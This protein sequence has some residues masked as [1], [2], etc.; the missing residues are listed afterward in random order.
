MSD[1]D[2]I[3]R[4]HAEVIRSFL[5]DAEPPVFQSLNATARDRSRRAVVAVMAGAALVVAAL[6]PMLLLGDSRAHLTTTNPP[7]PSVG[8]FEES[9]PVSPFDVESFLQSKLAGAFEDEAEQRIGVVVLAPSG[10]ESDVEGLL[11]GLPEFEGYTQLG[12]DLVGTA[13][14]RFAETHD[15]EPF[16]GEWVAFGLIP[17]FAD[18]PTTEWVSTLST[19]PDV[20]VALVD[21][22]TPTVRIP[23]GWSEVGDLPFHIDGGAIVGGF[24]SRI[25]VLQSDS[26]T[27]IDPDGSYRTGD[28][29]PISVPTDCCGSARVMPADEV[30]VVGSWIL[31]P[32]TLTWREADP[33][34]I[35]GSVLGSAFLDGELFVVTAAA[36]TGEAISKLAS[37]NTATGSW[38]ELES[39]PSPISVGGVTTDGKRLIVAGTRQDGNNLIIG[40][41]NPVVYQYT[42]GERW[43]ELPS[44]P[45]DG[46]ASTV[47]WVEGVGL[48]VWNYELQSALLDGSGTWR[49]LGDVPMPFSECYPVSFSTTG[50][51]VGLCDGVAFYDAVD[52]WVPLTGPSGT[53]YVVTDSAV[54]G[55]VPIGPSETK[56]VNYV[57]D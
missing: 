14:E 10:S 38:R 50:G 26:T 32:E 56:L 48:L 41:R 11:L 43:S 7:E 46:Q 24:G 17:R 18:S 42:P 1:L 55:L 21:F 54:F 33:R 16:G 53:R 49:E 44:V 40:D 52:G 2:Q 5:D 4:R 9:L 51:V 20:K 31:D 35:S 6:L 22:E 36:R 34:P 30:L 3:G 57:A 39:V 37:L 15:M 23:E 12:S 47:A 25:V 19:V 27:V 8:T 28:A 29:P 45:I 13:A